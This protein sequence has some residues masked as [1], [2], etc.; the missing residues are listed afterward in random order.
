MLP[1]KSQKLP[2]ESVHER[3]S[4]RP[5][6]TFDGEEVPRL[7]YTPGGPQLLVEG[8][9]GSWSPPPI[10]VHSSVEGL[11]FKRSLRYPRWPVESTPSPP[12]SQKFP[13]LSFHADE[14]LR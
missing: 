3:A 10:Q 9:V 14:P 8:Q 12:K 2:L 5:P 11:N 6:G 7:P 4:V 1:P 13:L